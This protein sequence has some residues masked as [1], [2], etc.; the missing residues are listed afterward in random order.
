[1]TQWQLS[2]IKYLSGGSIK[3]DNSGQIPQ[4][5]KYRKTF[6]NTETGELNSITDL[7]S[8]K[9]KRNKYFDLFQKTY[10]KLYKDHEVSILAIVVNQANYE[11]ISKFVNTLSRKLKRKEIDKYGY[12]WVRDIGD[13]TF[14]KH[15]HL[16]ISISRITTSQ[17]NELFYKKNNQDYEVQFMKSEKG[18]IRYIKEKELFGK[19]RQRTYGKSREFKV[20]TRKN[21]HLKKS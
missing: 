9:Y 17:F 13:E 8:K 19:K 4:I 6:V 12:V 10:A 15:F 1:M 5:A 20:P 21:I 14:E 2:N 3:S 7:D 11:T 16:I 18:L